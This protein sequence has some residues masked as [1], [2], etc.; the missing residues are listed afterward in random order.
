M[1]PNQ[2]QAIDGSLAKLRKT[3]IIFNLV[4]LILWI[5][6]QIVYFGITTHKLVQDFNQRSPFQN[7]DGSLLVVIIG[8]TSLA[9]ALTITFS[10]LNLC[11]HYPEKDEPTK[12]ARVIRFSCCVKVLFWLASI[13]YVLA[14][15][16]LVSQQ[17]NCN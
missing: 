2:Q 11:F 5:P 4:N 7:L 15:V 3:N 16:G 6:L 12:A 14:F 8:I 17:I 13:G 9:Y 1:Y 10:I